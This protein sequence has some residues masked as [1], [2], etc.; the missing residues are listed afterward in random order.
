V[1]RGKNT[2]FLGWELKGKVS[3]TLLDGK[4]VYENHHP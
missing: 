3:H 2:P 4:L 1:S